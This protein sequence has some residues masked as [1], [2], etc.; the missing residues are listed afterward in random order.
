MGRSMRDDGT[1]YPRRRP[2]NW[3][4]TRSIL[5][6]RQRHRDILKAGFVEVGHFGPWQYTQ[7]GKKIVEAIPH[8]DGSR[9]YVKLEQI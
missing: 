9:L 1:P 4:K 3:E 6:H 8:P 5:R 2:V 7:Q